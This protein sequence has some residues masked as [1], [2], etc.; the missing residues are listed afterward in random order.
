M[1]VFARDAVLARSKYWYHMKRQ[2]KVRKVQGE[3]VSTSE[4]FEKNTNSVKNY[5]IVLR[6]ETRTITVNMYKEYRATTLNGA[7]SQMYIEM[8]GR[9]SGRPE[10]IQII[11]TSIVKSTDLRRPATQ[12]VADISARFPKTDNRKRAPVRS[13]KTIYKASRPTLI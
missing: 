7:M 5:G 13:L 2:H 3:I 11:R 9:H 8:S 1:R 4:I 12:Q 6:Y 10:T